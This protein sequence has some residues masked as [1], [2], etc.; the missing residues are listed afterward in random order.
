[1]KHTT[2]SHHALWEELNRVSRSR[3]KVEVKVI[4]M[5][6]PGFANGGRRRE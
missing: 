2:N 5:A 1:M 3:V 6:D 4:V